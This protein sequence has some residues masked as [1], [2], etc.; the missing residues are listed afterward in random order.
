VGVSRETV[1]GGALTMKTRT[2]FLAV[3]LLLPSAVTLAE[4]RVPRARSPL[5]IVDTGY[6]FPSSANVQGIGAYFKTRMV[7]VNPTP[8]PMTIDM[9]LSTPGGPVGPQAV[10]LAPS[11]TRVY[12]NFLSDVFGYVGGAGIR[13]WE[14]T[15]TRP[16]LASGEVYADNPGG[17]YGT[18][19]WAM[20]IDDRVASVAESGLSL[21]PGLRVNA[22]NR[23]NYG[24]A[25]MDGSPVSVQADF[26]TSAGGT[27][28]PAKSAQMDLP[29]NGWAQAAVPVT[30]DLVNIR[31]RFFD[32]AGAL[33]VYCYGVAVNNASAD[34]TS[35]PAVY[36]PPTQ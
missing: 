24:C 4:D 31:F 30:D 16:F 35:V 17:R 2:W 19:I 11:E 1:D 21:S 8:N 14:S 5:G 22:A 32:G 3:A 12:E 9:L 15:N 28:T 6:V 20:S 13:L 18:S 34:G 36:V 10:N 7:L 29:A 23:S 33:G 26:Y 25:N 27:A